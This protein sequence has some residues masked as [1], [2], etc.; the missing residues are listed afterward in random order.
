[1]SDEDRE[2]ILKIEIPGTSVSRVSPGAWT[3]ITGIN[4]WQLLSSLIPYW[5]GTIDLSGY[6]M[7]YKT[8]Y[9]RG[10]AI[11]T[12]P[13][14]LEGP[15][16]AGLLVYTIV[17]TVPLDPLDL[18]S[19]LAAGMAPGFLDGIS[20]ATGNTQQDW[21]TVMFAQEELYCSDRNF[22]G[23]STSGILRRIGLNQSGSLEPTAADTLFV[24]KMIISLDAW[25][26]PQLFL[27]IPPARVILPGSM[28]QEPDL[29]YM[30]R[31]KRSLEL[32][33]QV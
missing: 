22:E 18:S 15:V 32:A 7:D 2:R 9:P 30:M 12:T 4:G 24:M 5:E 8:F 23:G 25:A 10:G 11:Q 3:D 26:G 29:E 14:T 31:L 19:R 1:M 33:N 13:L 27:E 21:N 6:A 16:S 17:S 20:A 28:N